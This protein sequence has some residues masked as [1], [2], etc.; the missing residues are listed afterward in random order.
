ME[1]PAEH[2]PRVMP[3][4]R[5]LA[6]TAVGIAA[7][8]LELAAGEAREEFE[9][10]IESLLLTAALVALGAL[11]LAMI[12]LAVVFGCGEEHRLAALVALAVV[13]SVGTVAIALRLRWRLQNWPSFP[14]TLQELRKDRSWLGSRDDKSGESE[15]KP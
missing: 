9:R 13:Y 7:N 5:S 1:P 12:T 11:A 4:L 2:P 8:R 15:S 10:W 3:T 6:R 14:A